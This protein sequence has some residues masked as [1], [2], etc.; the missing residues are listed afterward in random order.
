MA[1]LA[2]SNLTIPKDIAD[3]IV[4]DVQDGSAVATLSASSPFRFGETDI[5]TLNGRPKA[6]FVG[7]GAD[8]SSDTIEFGVV[9]ARPRKAQVTLRFNEEVQ[10]ADED[11]QLGVLAEVGQALGEAMT[12]ALDLGVLHAVNPLTGANLTG[13]P[14]YVGAST[15]VIDAT[16]DP[17]ADIEAA[18]GSLVTAAAPV[19]PTG[20]AL[21]PAYA[22]KLATSR[23]ANDG[24]KKFPDMP[25]S[26]RQVG[27]FMGMSAAVGDT[28]AAAAEVTGGTGISAIVGDWNR[29][30]RWGIAKSLPLEVIRFGDPD[31]Q[32]DLKRKNQIAL[33]VEAA[34]VWHVFTDK[35]ALI[36]GDDSD[37]DS[38]N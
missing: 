16:D 35:F 33:R 22:F 18:F 36:K 10:W 38:G 17:E 6:E 13:S 27:S 31:G 14:T 20:I 25:L 29:G 26:P 32:G 37:E 9:T 2:T 34:Y 8:K 23:Y 28:I 5:V 30:L 12:R 11:Y 7:E 3:G 1:V 21:D 24:R 15:N 19:T 4:K